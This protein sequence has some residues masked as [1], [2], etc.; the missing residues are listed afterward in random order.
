MTSLFS[1]PTPKENASVVMKPCLCVSCSCSR[2]H[3][4]PSAI[5]LKDEKDCTQSDPFCETFC[6]LRQSQWRD[7]MRKNCVYTVKVNVAGSNK[8]A[9]WLINCA[10]FNLFFVYKNLNRDSKLKYKA[11]VINVAKIW[12]TDQMVA[13]KRVSVR[14][15]PSTPTP[16]RPH[17]DTPGRLSGCYAET[18]PC[19]NCE[20]W[21][22]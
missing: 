13:A 19:E 14:P 7:G 1:Y 2:V 20:K 6:S 10:I 15:C 9:L 5:K 4:V 8:V 16:C 22:F 12:A 3:P 18:Y 21:T 17:V 11:F